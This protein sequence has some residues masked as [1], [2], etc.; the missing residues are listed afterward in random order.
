MCVQYMFT[1]THK[2]PHIYTHTDSDSGEQSCLRNPPSITLQVYPCAVKST[3]PHLLPE[4]LRK[5]PSIQTSANLAEI[6]SLFFPECLFFSTKNNK[7]KQSQMAPTG[8]LQGTQATPVWEGG[9][10]P[11]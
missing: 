5:F 3:F 7:A 2:D 10:P 9:A 11:K 1:H 8:A 6:S 4:L